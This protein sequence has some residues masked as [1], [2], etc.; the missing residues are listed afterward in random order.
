LNGAKALAI[1]CH[2]LLLAGK[3][4]QNAPNNS[5]AQTTFVESQNALSEAANQL[6]VLTKV[7]TELTFCSLFNTV[8]RHRFTLLLFFF[9][10][11]YRM[12]S[13]DWKWNWITP[14]SSLN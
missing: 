3:A 8:E 12:N 1:A 5:A 9:L 14:K 2:Q 11:L 7:H 6:I 4:V 10:R 13:L